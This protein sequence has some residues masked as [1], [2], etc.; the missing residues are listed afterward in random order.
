MAGCEMNELALA[1]NV[2]WVSPHDIGSEEEMILLPSLNLSQTYSQRH[3][4][5]PLS[6]PGNLPGFDQKQKVDWA[7]KIR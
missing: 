5:S 1:L 6:G 7:S 4:A 2:T 3:G